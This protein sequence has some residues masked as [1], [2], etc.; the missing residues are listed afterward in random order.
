M[1]FP[2]H[3][4]YLRGLAIL[5]EDVIEADLGDCTGSDLDHFLGHEPHMVEVYVG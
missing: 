1:F 3:Y 4:E 2:L 5:E